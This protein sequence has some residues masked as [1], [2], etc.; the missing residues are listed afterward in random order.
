MLPLPYGSNG[1]KQSTEQAEIVTYQEAVG[2]LQYASRILHPDITYAV[3]VGV[4]YQLIKLDMAMGHWSP[5][6]GVPQIGDREYF[7]NILMSCE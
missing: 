6:I 3:S 4:A 5:A 2:S 7:M 1:L